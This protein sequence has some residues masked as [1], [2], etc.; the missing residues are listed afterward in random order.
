MNFIAAKLYCT[1]VM[2]KK[3]KDAKK[4]MQ[5]V[6]PEPPNDE[7]ETDIR[8]DH[9]DQQGAAPPF[10]HGSHTAATRGIFQGDV[11]YDVAAPPPPRF[12]DAPYP[13]GRSRAADVF[14]AATRHLLESQAE[15]AKSLEYAKGFEN[16]CRV[17]AAEGQL[18][19]ANYGSRLQKVLKRLPELS[20]TVGQQLHNLTEDFIRERDGVVSRLYH[21]VVDQDR[22]NDIFIDRAATLREC[23]RITTSFFSDF[24]RHL[25]EEDRA[26]AS[27]RSGSELQLANMSAALQRTAKELVDASL[28]PISDSA[29]AAKH[30]VQVIDE[31]LALE[32]RS[33]QTAASE[34]SASADRDDLRRLVELETQRLQLAR[35]R[36]AQLKKQL[37]SLESSETLWRG[38]R[39]QTKHTWLEHPSPAQ[40]H[41]RDHARSAITPVTTDLTNRLVESRRQLDS[42]SKELDAAKEKLLYLQQYHMGQLSGQYKPVVVVHH[43]LPA[44]ENFLDP[45]TNMAVRA[46][47]VESLLEVNKALKPLT[48]IGSSSDKSDALNADNFLPALQNV[49]TLSDRVAIQ[50][51]VVSRINRLFTCMCPTAPPL[52]LLKNTNMI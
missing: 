29:M 27:Y 32:K 14:T 50:N 36:N 2:A 1:A 21:L 10:L 43:P 51:F 52:A 37:E 22:I 48:G 16:L 30:R 38:E 47:V 35:R 39:D 45:E 46:T 26:F 11:V 44:T 23:D 8:W 7:W 13:V 33:K 3:R 40:V 17:E 34:K 12:C 4:K 6:A 25:A 5:L 42:C 15:H 31:L 20:Y 9:I 24:S 28:K 19:R 18:T 49:Q 41:P